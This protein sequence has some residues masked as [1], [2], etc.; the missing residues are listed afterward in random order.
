MSMRYLAGYVSAF[1]D[2]L[3]VPNAPTFGT[4]TTGGTV[5]F[6]A[7]VNTGGGA[8]TSYIATATNSA[9]NATITSS[10]ISSPVAVTGLTDGTTYTFKVMAVNAYGPSENSATSNSIV[11]SDI[12][13]IGAAYEG[14]YFAGQI[15]TSG[16]GVADYNLVV[17]PAS[18]ADSAPIMWKNSG[19]T[20][21]GTSSN[22]NGPANTASMVAA[23]T[24]T[25]FPAAHF[26]N[27]LVVGS[28]SD[29]Y[30]PAKNEL[31]ICYYNLKPTTT[32]NLT[33]IQY[34]ANANSVPTRTTG[35]TTGTPA[36]TSAANFQS[37]GAEDF[38]TVRY[39]SSTQNDGSTSQAFFK[40]FDDGQQDSSFK[41]NTSRV[42]AVRRV[43]V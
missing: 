9:T 26:C 28:Y 33:A 18:T 13:P 37:T 16:N 2:P 17:G 19:G 43:P 39:W 1:Y 35:Y 36:Q 27:N 6:T 12:P 40:L 8:I 21:A 3:R 42:R 4:A 14:G 23:G 34:G 15:S 11:Y 32:S 5:S 7:P 25:V 24:S 29:W 20:T 22:I 30:M 31:E 38:S 10:G 41:Y